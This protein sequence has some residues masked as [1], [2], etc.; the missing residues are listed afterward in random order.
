V[1]ELRNIFLSDGFRDYY[2]ATVIARNRLGEELG[3]SGADILAKR[4]SNVKLTENEEAVWDS[5]QS[6]VGAMVSL[7]ENVGL[8][9]YRPVEA[10][11]ARQLST[12]I[13]LQFLPIT[14]QQRLGVPLEEIMPFPPELK[15]ALDEV[16][17]IRLY[18]GR[19]LGL[20]ESAYGQQLAK[21]SLFYKEVDDKQVAFLSRQ[22]SLDSSVREGTINKDDW[23]R[24]SLALTHEKIQFIEDLQESIMFRDMPIEF[25]DRVKWA[26]ENNKPIPRLSDAEEAMA[27]YF[28][29]EP[30]DFKRL[31][32]DT[33]QYEIDW[34]GFYAWQS[35]VLH[36][37]PIAEQDNFLARIHANETDL[38]EIRRL[39]Y[40]NYIAPYKGIFSI[41]VDKLD[42]DTRSLVLQYYSTDSKTVKDEIAARVDAYGKSI[43][44]VV[45]RDIDMTK[46]NLRRLN[47][48]LDARLSFWENT[49]MLSD[50]AK[51]I[52]FSLWD[53]YGIKRRTITP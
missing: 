17:L 36:A 21:L 10:E 12:Q 7:F 16:D 26:Q 48:E 35:A 47:P 38:Q 4:I 33:G 22:E 2:T 52:E 14:E 28:K 53:A 18:R 31:N 34:T 39:D 15:D 32:D 44:G 46:R 27:L 5:A 41:V 40:Q 51:E 1:R 3:I 11:R 30:E 20:Q 45:Q 37:V 23:H 6:Q 49:A 24:E 9:A 43:I 19:T 8:L 29:L 50:R 42:D 13:M 25:D